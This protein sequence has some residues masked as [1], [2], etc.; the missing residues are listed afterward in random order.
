MK[1][2]TVFLLIMFL[3]LAA[4]GKKGNPTPPVPIIPKATS[5][6]AVAQRGPEIL[7]SWSYPALTTTGRK[8][9]TVRSITILRY[10]ENL[11]RA[12]LNRESIAAAESGTP[13]PVELFK[14]VPVLPP[15]Q[16]TKL[17]T[18][19]ARIA[20]NEVPRHSEGAQ[21]FYSDDPQVGQNGDQPVRISYAVVT[22]GVGGKSDLSNIVSIVPLQVAVPPSG[23]QATAAPSGITLT[24]SRPAAAVTPGHTP[25]I[26]G[27]NIY[28]F[29][30]TGGMGAL[31]SPINKSPVLSTTYQDV[32]PYGSYRYTVTAVSAFGP[33]LVQSESSQPIVA[34]YRDL[35]PPPEPG[36]IS[37]LV[38]ETAIRTL[39][40]AVVAPD[41]KGYKVYRTVIG[42]PRVLLTPQPIAD[43]NLR[44][45]AVTRGSVYRYWV[46]SVDTNG[47]ES[48]AKPTDPVLFPR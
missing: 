11:P 38:E 31:D 43:T 6:L 42:G 22:A 45:T 13:R 14:D 2:K 7:L 21:L 34:E 4:C 9:E 10:S 33:P 25:D 16:F 3:A 27:Y 18:A 48:A 32:P 12:L 40:D 30:A 26:A 5:D 29:P 24:W 35:V 8:L 47:N 37:A 39:W 1:S 19:V 44:D 46:S 20:G 36:S 23:V 41:L 28:R 15:Q 17:A